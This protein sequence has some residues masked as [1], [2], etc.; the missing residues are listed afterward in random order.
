MAGGCCGLLSG[1][2]FSRVNDWVHQELP[3]GSDPA[4]L[5]RFRLRHGFR[6]VAEEGARWWY[7][8]ER[9]NLAGTWR[10]YDVITDRCYWDFDVIDFALL[11]DDSGKVA[12]FILQRHHYGY[13]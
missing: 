3:I 6:P 10:Y 7:W 12:Y 5:E 4:T 13:S 11:I 1:P 2:S 9:P 8:M